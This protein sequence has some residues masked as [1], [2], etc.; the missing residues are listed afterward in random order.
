MALEK[1]S[2]AIRPLLAVHW[3]ERHGIEYD[4]IYF[5][6]PKGVEKTPDG[7]RGVNTE[8]Y[9]TAEIRRMAF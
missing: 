9:T 1:D 7:E 8:V 6:K 3:L 5:G 2:H 4:E